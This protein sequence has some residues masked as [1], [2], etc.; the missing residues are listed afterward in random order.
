M[1]K[2]LL[3]LLTLLLSVQ[4]YA[5]TLNYNWIYIPKYPNPESENYPT[6]MDNFMD[7]VDTDLWGIQQNKLTA[8]VTAPGTP[9]CNT[10]TTGVEIN[11]DGTAYTW[12]KM[13]WESVSGSDIREYEVRVKKDSE[14]DY[15]YTYTTGLSAIFRPV[16]AESTYYF[17]V[18]AIDKQ[19]NVGSYC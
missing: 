11:S 5:G 10:P 18:R 8:D 19:G 12:L 1:K 3:T 14:A 15:T 2:L 6:Y 4:C 16:I 9:V 7:D 17:D 13:S